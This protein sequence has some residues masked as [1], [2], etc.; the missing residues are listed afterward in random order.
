LSC[1]PTPLA[2][3][4]TSK[5]QSLQGGF[6]PFVVRQFRTSVQVVVE[7][8]KLQMLAA[9]LVPTESGKGTVDYLP[10]SGKLLELRDESG[11]VL[12]SRFP[13]Y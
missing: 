11:Q 8:R 1:C 7:G 9:P 12:W 2:N 13:G 10:A 5:E 6:G 3:N 4:A